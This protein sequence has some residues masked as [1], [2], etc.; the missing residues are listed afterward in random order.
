MKTRTDLTLTHLDNNH[1]VGSGGLDLQVRSDS[2]L[3]RVVVWFWSF[4]PMIEET[5]KIPQFLERLDLCS[6]SFHRFQ[7]VVGFDI[8]QI[9]GSL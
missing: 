7:D 8:V 4:V 3:E 2:Q 9:Q 5:V 1:P 6:R